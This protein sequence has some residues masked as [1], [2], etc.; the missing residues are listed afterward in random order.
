M[1]ND[2][3][4]ELSVKDQLKKF[5]IKGALGFQTILM[6]GIGTRLGI[7]NY[8]YEKGKDSSE[9]KKDS[10]VSFTLDE[11]SQNLKLDKRYL[12]AWLHMLLECGLFEIDP[13]ADRTLKTAPHVYEILINQESMFYAGGT[14][15]CIYLMAKYQDLIVKN[16]K[17]GEVI[18]FLESYQTFP[19]DNR[20]G[21]GATATTAPQIEALF[22]R[23]CKEHKHI[24]HKGGPLLEVGCGY[25]HNLVFWAKKYKEARIVGIDIDPI[26]IAYTKD[27]VAKNNWSDRI[28]I[29]HT[30]IDEFTRSNKNKFYVIFLNQVLHE[31][32]PDENY[33]RNVLTNLYAMLQDGGLLIVV[34]NMIPDMFTP[35]DRFLF[36][37]IWHKCFEVVL[38]SKFY[39]EQEFLEF[40][41]T[42]PFK[43]AKLIKERNDYFWAL[44]KKES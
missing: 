25:G 18:D 16:F 1:S 27:V 37:E 14:L 19:E 4:S 24:L 41:A 15:N 3:I 22:S 43:T 34:E 31:M 39:N 29:L 26:A 40:V 36:F 35:K 30:P 17:T 44:M 9:V 2:E 32:D 21:Q 23:Y 11:L 6:Y 38:N 8:L 20:L 10:S 28:E 13:S 33:R 42:T 7:F 12:D 5:V